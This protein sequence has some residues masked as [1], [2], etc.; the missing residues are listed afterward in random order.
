MES[1]KFVNSAGP[2]L[3]HGGAPIFINKSR[4]F[5]GLPEIFSSGHIGT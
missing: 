1:T 2:V 5:I 3:T 4:D